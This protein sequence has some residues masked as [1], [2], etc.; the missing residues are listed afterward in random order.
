MLTLLHAC[1]CVYNHNRHWVI[2][3]LVA[4]I[5]SVII[6][7]ANMFVLQGADYFQLYGG[8]IVHQLPI[9]YFSVMLIPLTCLLPELLIK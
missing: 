4:L 9:Y 6:F 5:L 7:I 8:T 2:W 1:V 3:N